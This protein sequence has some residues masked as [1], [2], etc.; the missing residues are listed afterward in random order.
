MEK[1]I[2]ANGAIIGAQ[3]SSY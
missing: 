1:Q 2:R 3:K